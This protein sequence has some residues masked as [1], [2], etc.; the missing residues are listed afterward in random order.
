MFSVH[1]DKKQL[2]DIYIQENNIEYLIP[3]PNTITRG[4]IE[5]TPEITLSVPTIQSIEDSGNCIA[6]THMEREVSEFYIFDSCSSGGGTVSSGGSS[7]TSGGTTSTVNHTQNLINLIDDLEACNTLNGFLDSGFGLFGASKKCYANFD[8]KYR[9]KT[10]YWK[11]NYLIWNSIGVKVKHQKKGWTGLWR[12]KS[13]DEVALSISQATFKYT[14]NIPNFPQSYAP[15]KLF[16]FED[17]IFNS[18]SQLM[19]YSNAIYKPPFP[20]MP[21][22]SDVIITEYVNDQIGSTFTVDNMREYFYTGAW[23]IAKLIVQN[24]RNRLPKNVT[25]ILYTPTQ[26]LVNYVDIENRV[27]NTKKIVN[28]LD[29]NFGIGFKFNVYVDSNGNYS[30]N[31]GNFANNPL[32]FIEIPK[33]YDYSKVKMDFVGATR[34]GNVWK[35]SRIIYT[36]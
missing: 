22:I 23:Q 26:I 25:H 30:T 27:L 14:I 17:K 32:G 24:E 13:T 18:Q 12:A 19:S 3:D 10:K 6:D 20:D 11:E 36:D 2:L 29:Y 8:S 31:L 16:F 33:L 4:E 1:K 21:F 28:R 15:L 34:K 7:T 9:T 35:G 5:P